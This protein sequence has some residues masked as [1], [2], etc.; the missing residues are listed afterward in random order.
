MAGAGRVGVR[1][2]YGDFVN[3]YGGSYGSRL[4]LVQLP[5]CAVTSPQRP[6]CRKGTPVAT[7][8]DEETKTLSADVDAAPAALG[9]TVLA[10]VAG[11]SSDKGDYA[12]TSLS[13]SATWQVASRPETSPGP[14]PCGFRRCPVT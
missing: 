10:A 5:A 6:G 8:N 1:V 12:A 13:A 14:I 11:S 7:R 4:R 9:G 3:A 2:D